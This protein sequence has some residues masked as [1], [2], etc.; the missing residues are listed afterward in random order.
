M[1]YIWGIKNETNIA[2]IAQPGW[3]KINKFINVGDRGKTIS[4]S[5]FR[6]ILLELIKAVP[7]TPDIAWS[8]NPSIVKF[9]DLYIVQE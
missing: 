3:L 6:A 8:K 4:S 5:K 1:V 2:N 7:K 9:L